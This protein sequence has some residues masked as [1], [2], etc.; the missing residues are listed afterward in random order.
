MQITNNIRPRDQSEKKVTEIAQANSVRYSRPPS[1]VNTDVGA[2]DSA[3]KQF[4][5]DD[6]VIESAAYRK[7]F[8]TYNKRAQEL[9][10]T[11]LWPIFAYRMS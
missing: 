7:A 6:Q 9:K 1:E 10:A 2:A 5:F 4:D 8:A 3:D 11:D